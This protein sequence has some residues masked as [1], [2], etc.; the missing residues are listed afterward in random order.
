MYILLYN[1]DHVSVVFWCIA[2]YVLFIF[3]NTHVWP[4][5]VFL[6]TGMSRGFAFVE[7]LSVDNARRWMDLYQVYF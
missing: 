7:L 5:A 3:H 4:L 2:L 6:Y 1:Y